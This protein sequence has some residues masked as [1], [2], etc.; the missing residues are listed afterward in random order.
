MYIL[1]ISLGSNYFPSRRPAS[2]PDSQNKVNWIIIKSKLFSRVWTIFS[3][4]LLLYVYGIYCAFLSIGRIE[5]TEND[6]GIISYVLTTIDT[7]LINYLRF[8]AQRESWLVYA[9]KTGMV[10]STTY[11]IYPLISFFC[12]KFFVLSCYA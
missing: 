9:R 1:T 12:T 7:S 4:K 8:R 2:A 11:M 3:S 5:F 6:I 10:F